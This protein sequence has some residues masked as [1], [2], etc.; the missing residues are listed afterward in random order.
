VSPTSAAVKL[1]FI[2]T[3][4]GKIVS[5]KAIVQKLQNQSEILTMLNY[6]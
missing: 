3:S 2:S 4:G 6:K 1:G 5:S